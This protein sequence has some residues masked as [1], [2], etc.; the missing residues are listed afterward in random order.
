MNGL[1]LSP[2]L[3]PPPPPAPLGYTIHAWGGLDPLDPFEP[4]PPIPLFPKCRMSKLLTGRR[5][6]CPNPRQVA[7]P[8][9]PTAL[10]SGGGK[11]ISGHLSYGWEGESVWR[12]E[13]ERPLSLI[14]YGL[15]F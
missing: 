8:R 12:T 1:P 15:I 7:I 2:P 5:R 9:L 10:R 6:G 11:K 14:I 3:P 4:S 13:H